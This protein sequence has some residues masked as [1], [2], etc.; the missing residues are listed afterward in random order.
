MAFWENHHLFVDWC[1]NIVFFLH[2]IDFSVENGEFRNA[3][4]RIKS[5]E[6]FSGGFECL[7]INV[8]LVTDYSGIIIM[9][10]QTFL[11]FLVETSRNEKIQLNIFLGH[12]FLAHQFHTAFRQRWKCRMLKDNLI[13]ENRRLFARFLIMASMEFHGFIKAQRPRTSHHIWN[14][15]LSMG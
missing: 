4:E 10:R 6:S 14:H 15:L 9:I 11:T 3:A 13:K 8:C 12:E 1:L 7:M 2:L 5:I